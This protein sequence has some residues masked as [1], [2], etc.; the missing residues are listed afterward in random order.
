M[1]STCRWYHPCIA[2]Y[3]IVVHGTNTTL[4]REVHCTIVV[5]KSSDSIVYSVY[6]TYYWQT[7]WMWYKW[8]AGRKSVGRPICNLMA[9]MI[10]WGFVHV[11]VCDRRRDD[12]LKPMYIIY[13]IPIYD[14]SLFFSSFLSLYLFLSDH[15]CA[16]IV[17]RHHRLRKV[18]R[19]KNLKSITSSSR[20]PHTTDV[21][22]N[23]CIL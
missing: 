10:I 19:I 14:V 5:Y 16:F 9:S 4:A 7:P 8:S 12:S 18:R 13:V 20:F 21:G 11:V 2:Y 17:Y 22:N 6:Y 3:I 23:M 15:L 1:P